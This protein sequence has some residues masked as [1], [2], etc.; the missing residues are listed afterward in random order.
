[1]KSSVQGSVS[2]T[3]SYVLCQCQ[4]IASSFDLLPTW[5]L[6]SIIHFPSCWCAGS[7]LYWLVNPCHW[8]QRIQGQWLGNL[9]SALVEVFTP[10]K[11]V[12]TT[13]HGPSLSLSLIPERQLLHIYQCTT[14]YNS[15]RDTVWI[16]T[17]LKVNRGILGALKQTKR[18]KTKQKPTNMII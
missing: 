13:N 18:N 5:S 12:F 10:Q 4:Q 9:K 3:V 11:L 16:V 8:L 15:E 14:A 1:M 7:S 6:D 17:L 2:G